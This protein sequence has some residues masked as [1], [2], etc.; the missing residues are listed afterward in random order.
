MNVQMN[1]SGVPIV[2][3]K[4]L[5]QKIKGVLIWVILIILTIFAALLVYL[6]FV[7][8]SEM[9][10]LQSV[11]RVSDH[12]YYTM[13]I[14]GYDYTELLNSEASD[15]SEVVEYCKHKLFTDAL[16][17]VLPGEVEIDDTPKG[18]VA[19]YAYTY[20]NSYMKGRIYNSYDTP[21]MMVISEPESGYKSWNIV[22]MADLGIE[23]ETK[24]NQWYTNAFQTM[25]AVYAV[26]EGVNSQGLSVSLVSC[27]EAECDD[28]VNVNIT[29]FMAVR[30]LL[31]RAATVENAVDV[32]ED[33]DID[34]SSGTYHILVSQ[35]SSNSAVIEWIDGEMVVTY[36]KDEDESA[37]HQTMSNAMVSEDAS[38]K[39]YDDKYDEI[40]LFDFY[41]KAFTSSDS[42]GGMSQDYALQILK[43]KGSDYEET[44]EM[45]YGTVMYGTTYM[46]FYDFGEKTMQIIVENDSK[47]QSYTYD[48]SE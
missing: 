26:S 37:M 47:T 24:I 3:E 27:P 5:A 11:K 6:C 29:P 12:P 43:R 22:D 33:Y 2:R 17:S 44:D 28:T 9:G 31:D 16:V 8:G 20:V 40:E 42:G 48:I 18:S 23:S 21:I 38:V 25:A 30:L 45:H 19:W 36:M 34:F 1:D 39:D 15:N 14:E 7:G 32:L 35:E 10:A 13:T 4:T 46:V 41:D